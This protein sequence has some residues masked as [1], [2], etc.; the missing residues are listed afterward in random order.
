MAA[1][2]EVLEASFAILADGNARTANDILQEGWRRGVFERTQSQKNLYAALTHYVERMLVRGRK[3]VIVQDPDRRFR[4]NRPIDDWPAVDTTGLAPLAVP[5]VSRG[6]AT[7]ITALQHAARSTNSDAFER[8]VCALFE[9]LGFAATHVG[10]YHAPDGYADAL[11]GP[12]SYR[13]MLECK[14]SRDDNIAHSSAVAEAA[15]Y[16]DVYSAGYCALVAVS[17]D[18]EMT[19]VSELVDR[20]PRGASTISFGPQRYS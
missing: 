6:A 13:V 5:H 12:L 3:P 7:A 17:F 10:G 19:F 16:R 15:K 8:A 4:L 2:G 11:L 18:A 14:L 1:K 9:L 20:S